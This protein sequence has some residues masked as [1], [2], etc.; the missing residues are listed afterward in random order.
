MFNDL[1][2]ALCPYGELGRILFIP[3][4]GTQLLLT[5]AVVSAWKSKSRAKIWISY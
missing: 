3:R 1:N 2:Q 5:D 4:T